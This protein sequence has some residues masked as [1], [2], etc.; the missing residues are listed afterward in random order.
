MTNIL[1]IEDHLEILENTA[2]FLELDGFQVNCATNGLEGLEMVSRIKPDLI[3]SDILMPEMDGYELL[4][5]I[6]RD[7]QTSSIPFIFLT[8]KAEKSDRQLGLEMGADDYLTK[9]FRCS[10]LLNTIHHCLQKKKNLEEQYKDDLGE[11][12]DFILQKRT[13]LLDWLSQ[14]DYLTKYHEH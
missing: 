6:N 10:D 8:A 9:P 14:D 3:I 7:P 11:L 5:K 2:E 13:E 1:L 12:N 4:K